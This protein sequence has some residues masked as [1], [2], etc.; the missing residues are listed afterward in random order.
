MKII[1]IGYWNNSANQYP[2]Y[3]LPIAQKPYDNKEVVSMIKFI[4]EKAHPQYCKGMSP[5]RLCSSTNGSSEYQVTFKNTKYVIPEGYLHYIKE[6]FV[7]PDPLI[8]E[9]YEKLLKKHTNSFTPSKE[10]FNTIKEKYEKKK[11]LIS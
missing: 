10:F 11:R 9:I 3:P 4:F 5:C 7:E 8:K 6:H 2:E 1:Y